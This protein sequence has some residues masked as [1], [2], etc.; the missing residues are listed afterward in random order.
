MV[1]HF[2]DLDVDRLLLAFLLYQRK[3]AGTIQDLNFQNMGCK[4][5]VKPPCWVI[6]VSDRRQH[7]GCSGWMNVSTVVLLHWP[8]ADD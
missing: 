7:L 8:L 2:I 4:H 6:A 3:R 1:Q 5:Q